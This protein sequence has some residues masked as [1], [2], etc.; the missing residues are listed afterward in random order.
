M[1]LARCVSMTSCNYLAWI[2][3]CSCSFHVKMRCMR[4]WKVYRIQLVTVRQTLR[5]V[6]PRQCGSKAL[7]GRQI[8]KA[9]MYSVSK[10]KN[11]IWRLLRPGNGIS[12]FEKIRWR[13]PSSSKTD[14][15]FYGLLELVEIVRQW[16]FKYIS[17]S[18][19]FNF[20]C[21]AMIWQYLP[22]AIF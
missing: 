4:K 14:N 8:W 20:Y 16:N 2:N 1:L 17:L 5:Y 22:L 9:W 13:V 15:I 19:I 7:S 21:C 6:R 10:Y 11:Y 18:R 12:E 3:W